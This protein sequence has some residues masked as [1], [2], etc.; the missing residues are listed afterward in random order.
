MTTAAHPDSGRERPHTSTCVAFDFRDKH[1]HKVEPAALKNWLDRGCFLWIDIESESPQPVAAMLDAVGA[2]DTALVLDALGREPTTQSARYPDS[3]YMTIIGVRPDA[4]NLELE[5][6]DAVMLE[7]CMI[8]VHHGPVW[9]LGEL[10]RECEADFRKHAQTPSFLVYELWD[11]VLE[12]YQK[13]HQ[14]LE[15]RV[16]QLQRDMIHKV[17]DEVY[18]RV[19]DMDSDLLDF[20]KIVLPAR[21]VLSELATRKSTFVNEGTQQFL[22][23]MVPPV[24]L[25][26]QDI[27]VD[28]EILTQ[29]LNLSLSMVAHRTNETV[30]R[31]TIV[32]VIFLPLTFL[33]G[34]YGMNFQRMP[35]LEWE[36]GYFLFWGTVVVVTGTLVLLLRR[37]KLL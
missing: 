36:W 1:M 5:R 21:A 37:V 16:S 11:H 18:R 22:A 9:F 34:V 6:L 35:E 20:R 12:N 2:S 14:Q 24:E 3:L 33:C 31:L 28:R 17:D 4:A 32:S 15:E 23:N 29:T 7:N 13:V 10:R 27:L 26:L 25:I 19:A 8:S 30:K